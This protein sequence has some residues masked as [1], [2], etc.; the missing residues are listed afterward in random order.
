MIST[1]KTTYY[2]ENLAH[3]THDR[4]FSTSLKKIMKRELAVEKIL[5]VYVVAE[6]GDAGAEYLFCFYL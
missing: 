2:V 6:P 5:S 3:R 4:K 1:S